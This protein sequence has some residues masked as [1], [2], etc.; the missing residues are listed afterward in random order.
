MFS[1]DQQISP[2]ANLEV[3]LINIWK[4]YFNTIDI[5]NEFKWCLLQKSPEHL[6]LSLETNPKLVRGVELLVGH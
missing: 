2:Q 5:S 3:S 1:K 6:I 4:T